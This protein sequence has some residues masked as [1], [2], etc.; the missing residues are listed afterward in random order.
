MPPPA[1]VEYTYRL[2]WGYNTSE[3]TE[4]YFYMGECQQLIENVNTVLQ[5]ISRY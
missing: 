1:W 2:S 4:L 5:E 3:Y